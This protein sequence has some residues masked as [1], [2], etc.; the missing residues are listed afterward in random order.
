M[1]SYKNGY[2]WVAY[3][4]RSSFR[5]KDSR[6]RLWSIET[7]NTDHLLNVQRYLHDHAKVPLA[8][9][10]RSDPTG[11]RLAREV[12]NNEVARRGRRAKP[13]LRC[14][15]SNYDHQIVSRGYRQ[16]VDTAHVEDRVVFVDARTTPLPT[17]PAPPVEGYGLG[18][19]NQD[20][21]NTLSNAVEAMPNGH[22]EIAYAS[23]RVAKITVK[24]E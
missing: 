19:V 13:S 21:I 12:V 6:G 10:Y 7:I 20:M 3:P 15:H 17:P 4:S 11:L 18:T 23:G 24:P 22:Y 8:A 16:I 5:W 14:E 1:D 9:E 2:G